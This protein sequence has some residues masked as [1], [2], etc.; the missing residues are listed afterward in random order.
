MF[1]QPFGKCKYPIIIQGK[2]VI[3]TFNNN[4]CNYHTLCINPCAM[5]LTALFVMKTTFGHMQE[6]LNEISKA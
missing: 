1:N 5:R 4:K 6:L 2:A 3:H